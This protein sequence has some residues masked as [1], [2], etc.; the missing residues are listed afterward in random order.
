MEPDKN[1]VRQRQ[2][3]KDSKELFKQSGISG[4]GR[5]GNIFLR[6]IQTILITRMLGASGFGLYVLAR[7]S[8]QMLAIIGAYGLGPT[9]TRLIP[10][11]KDNPAKL[12]GIL[13]YSI[14]ISLFISVCLG[15]I[16]I[17]LSGWLAETVFNQPELK[18]VLMW[19]CLSIPIQSLIQVGYGILRGH[20]KIGVRVL[21][22]NLIF[23]SVSII[24]LLTF[25]FLQ[26][27]ILAVV[28]SYIVAY[29][30]TL[31]YSGYFVERISNVFTRWRGI[32]ISDFNSRE[33]VNKMAIPLLFS[34]SL[35]FVQKW[36]DTFMLGIFSTAMSVGIYAIS[37][38]VAAF[39]QIPLTAM[40]MIFGPM[41]AEIS[42]S[43]DRQR[44][45]D[46][47]KLVTRT[48]LILSLPIFCLIFL[49]PQELLYMFGK[50]FSN[51]GRALVLI[52]LGQ[53]INV[54]VGSTAQML[55]QTGKA[56]VHMYNSVVFLLLTITLNWLLIPEHGIIGAAIANAVT[57]ATLNIMRLVQIYRSMKIHPFSKGFF[58]T[59]SIASVTLISVLLMSTVIN[60]EGAILRVAILGGSFSVLYFALTALFGLGD[61][62]RA[63]LGSVGNKFKRKLSKPKG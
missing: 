4:L 60:V 62:E 10:V 21:A 52:C 53:I 2:R 24:L 22:E 54:S 14:L 13:K 9:L 58:A 40:N 45:A 57:L 18:E 6:Y 47:Y 56:K 29:S 43:G 50:D 41:V 48:S 3:T 55:V 34:S 12:H 11:S 30:F 28:A 63:L 59:I 32:S 16:L 36:A 23:P 17:P 27:G 7:N 5:F 46:A 1:Q 20:K 31:A 8:S 26:L 19:F 38:R 33:E 51:G 49:F 39:I 35:D 61:E 42:A 15:L 25:S 44:L 37:L